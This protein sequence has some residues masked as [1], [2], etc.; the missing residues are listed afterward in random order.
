MN[1]SLSVAD[2]RT[3]PFHYGLF[4]SVFSE[5]AAGHVLSWL[6][7]ATYWKLATTDFYEQYEFCIDDVNLP[8]PIKF[9]HDP[10]FTDNLRNAMQ[11]LFRT[12][13]TKDV[14][15]IAHKLMPNQH[16]GI[17]NDVLEGGESH[18]LTVQLNR[19]SGES[20]G[21]YFMLFNSAD[22]KDV[23][24]ILRPAHNS[25]V[26]FAISKRSYHAVT[27]QHGGT[28]FSLVFSFYEQ[29]V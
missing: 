15:S 17:H 7:G 14:R 12:S 1:L 24:R 3:M 13:L 26:A 25:A 11:E 9:M 16:I 2:V 8:A 10:A 21:G 20:A 18:R 29:P 27:Q 19:D 28:R 5:T 23:H 22:V 4:H 6:E